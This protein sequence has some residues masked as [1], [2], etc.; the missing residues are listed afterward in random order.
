MARIR[1]GESRA[2]LPTAV[3]YAAA[4]RYRSERHHP[5]LGGRLVLARDLVRRIFVTVPTRTS[6]PRHES[7]IFLAAPIQVTG[8]TG[9]NQGTL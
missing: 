5:E 4:G 3:V 7:M 2:C 9:M 1:P 8:E 6:W